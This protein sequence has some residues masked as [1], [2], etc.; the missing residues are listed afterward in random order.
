M[1]LNFSY[2]LKHRFKNDED[3][4]K[5]LKNINDFHNRYNYSVGVQM[6]LTQ[7]VINEWKMVIL[8][9]INL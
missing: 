7:H 4:L 1:D 9:L 6:I 8:K 5:V 2:D 3:R